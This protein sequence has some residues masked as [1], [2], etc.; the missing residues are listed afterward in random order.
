VTR[1]IVA[2]KMNESCELAAEKSGNIELV[3]CDLDFHK[4]HQEETARGFF[5]LIAIFVSAVAANA[6]VAAIAVR[7][8]GIMSTSF[9]ECV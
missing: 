8:S 1:V 9:V 7:F 2:L 4:I 6:S 5:F 3:E